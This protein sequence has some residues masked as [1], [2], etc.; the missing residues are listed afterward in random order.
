MSR[1]R[2]LEVK[3]LLAKPGKHGCG[4]NLWLT[5]TEP[6]RGT[7]SFRATLK[8]KSLEM[9]LGGTRDVPYAEACDAADAAR[10][11]VKA[12]INPV[13]QRR[14]QKQAE[15]AQTEDHSFRR[16]ALDYIGA[17]RA[18]WRNKQHA[19]QWSRTLEMFA[20]PRIG[21]LAANT[22]TV[23]HALDILRPIWANKTETAIRLRGRCEVIW[24]AAKIR[25]WCS[26][27]N[28]FVWRGNLQLLLAQPSKVRKVEHHAALPWAETPAF[29]AKLAQTGGTAALALRL[30]ILTAARS[31]EV[32]LA[33]WNEIDMQ[34]GFWTVPAERTKAS[35][36]H[37]VPLSK[38][39]LAVLREAQKLDTDGYIFPGSR[40]GQPLADMALIMLLRR[41]GRGDLTAHGFR[42]TFR[43]WCAEATSY[44]RELAET[45]LAHVLRDKT[46]AAY[47]RG[48]LLEKRRRLM[49]AWANFCAAPATTAEV[50]PIRA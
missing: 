15:A 32:R 19:W 28:P 29:M 16:A 31:G 3:S 30:L 49:T 9:G 42:S 25:G 20:Y 21:D 4:D 26:G 44:P 47:Q 43:D 5:V 1:L 10:K 17:H 23:E 8:G 7:W 45:A 50:V 18:E 12:G 36:L 27:E 11:L 35:R 41:M 37:R 14:D 48:D 22:I 40:A 2:W 46:E 38:A 6:G 13:E 24:S 34:G 39:A 33:T